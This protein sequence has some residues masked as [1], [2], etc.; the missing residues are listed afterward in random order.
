[1]LNAGYHLDPALAA[2]SIAPGLFSVVNED[3]RNSN[4]YMRQ[5]TRDVLAATLF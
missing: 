4:R 3:S 1:M 5:L 2:D